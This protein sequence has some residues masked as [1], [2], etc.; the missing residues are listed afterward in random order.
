MREAA[1][2]G[3]PSTVLRGEEDVCAFVITDTDCDA[4][5]LR[6]WCAERLSAFKLPDQ[7]VFVSDFPG[8]ATMRVAKHEL[9]NLIRQGATHA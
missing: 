4:E 7:I 3:I 6:R 1:V 9:V 2:V 5:A 8:T